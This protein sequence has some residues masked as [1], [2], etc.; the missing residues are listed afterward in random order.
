MQ[1]SGGCSAVLVSAALASAVQC[2]AVQC[3]AVLCSFGEGSAVESAVQFWR[4]QRSLP[5]CLSIL[6]P[7]LQTDRPIVFAALNGAHAHMHAL[8][9]LFGLQ[10]QSDWLSFLN[11]DSLIVSQGL[12]ITCMFVYT[13]TSTRARMRS[14]NKCQCPLRPFRH[15]AHARLFR[16]S[17]FAGR[18]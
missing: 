1:C 12:V 3:S 9:G 16:Y 2:S 4:V 11:P 6:P 5:F 10:A 17:V 13:H 18:A 7:S 15:S 14:I 8:F